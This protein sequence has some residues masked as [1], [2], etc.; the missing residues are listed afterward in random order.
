[1]YQIHKQ[2]TTQQFVE[3]KHKYFSM[4]LFKGN[5]WELPL[6]FLKL[7]YRLLQFKRS[8]FYAKKLVLLGKRTK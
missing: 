4:Y 6:K 3:Y 7:P 1:M 8:V 2:F 5:K